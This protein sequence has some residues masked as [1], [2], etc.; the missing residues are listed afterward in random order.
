MWQHEHSVTRFFQ[1]LFVESMSM[2]CTC[3]AFVAEHT[4]QARPSR[5]MICGF[6]ALNARAECS[7]SLA[8]FTPSRQPGFFSASICIECP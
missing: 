5:L 2:W 6:A 1:A 3:N 4:T 7:S 8:L